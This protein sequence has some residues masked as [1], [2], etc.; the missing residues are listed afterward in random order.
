MTP[1]QEFLE[2]DKEREALES[3]LRALARSMGADYREAEIL[4]DEHGVDY[5]PDRLVNT[6]HLS[7]AQRRT[8]VRVLQQIISISYRLSLALEMSDQPEAGN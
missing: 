4:T 6:E 5:V 7:A 8:L 3:G 2:L 1:W